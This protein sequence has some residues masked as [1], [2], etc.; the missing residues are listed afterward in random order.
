MRSVV[1]GKRGILR[2]TQILVTRMVTTR[3]HRL[4]H[5][6]RAAVG[7]RLLWAERF[8]SRDVRLQ[9][10]LEIRLRTSGS[11][12]VFIEMLALRSIGRDEGSGRDVDDLL[13]RAIHYCVPARGD[14]FDAIDPTL[15]IL[16]ADR[17]AIGT[18]H[19]MRIHVSRRVK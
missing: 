19:D 2:P 10:P 12:K 15:E 14:S 4:R 13:I 7:T 16:V 6:A 1:R 17:F 5:L 18:K 3:T 9:L 8:T 11:I